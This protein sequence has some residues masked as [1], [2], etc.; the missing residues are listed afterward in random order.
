MLVER[1]GELVTREEIKK[2]LWPNDT[3]VEFDHSIHTA[4]NKLRQALGDSADRPKYVETVARRGYR[5]MVSVEYLESAP[6]DMHSSDES[7]GEEDS[8]AARLQ[9]AS[10][11]LIGRTVSHYRVLDV[12]GG[13]GMGVVYKAEDLKLGRAVALKFLPEEL[14]SDPRALERFSREA[15]AASSL[16]HPNICAIHEFGEHAGRPFMVMQLLEGQTL[17]DRLANTA[18]EGTLRL[19]ELLDIGIQVSD[20]LQAAHEKGII[21]RDI[22]PANIFITNKG[23]CKILDFGLV[24]LL[25][26]D[27]ED[28]VAEARDEPSKMASTA[29]TLTRTGMAMGT[30][31][32]M[33]PEQVRGEKL[34]AR[35]DLFSFGLVLYEMATGQRAF[36]GETA[37]VL[38]DAILNDMPTP[39]KGLNSTLPLK[40]EK[41]IGKAIEKQRE[42]RYQA[43]TD[44]RADLQTL[45]N[46]NRHGLLNR[47]WKYIL[48]AALVLVAIGSG[49]Y[50]RLHRTIHLSGNDTIVLADFANFTGDPIF[51]GALTC[52]LEIELRQSPFINLLSTEKVHNTLRQMNIPENTG[53][54]PL[55]VR[56]VCRRTNSR[57]EVEGS[58]ADRGNHYRIELKAVDCQTGNPLAVAG[59]EVAERNE[60]VRILGI[61]GLQLRDRLGEPKVSLQ[62]FDKPLEETVT[63]SPEALQEFT[64][65]KG[66]ASQGGFR[67]D[68]VIHYKRASELDPNFALA[69]GQLG[70]AYYN[71]GQTSL[72]T[73]NF[74]KLYE[75]RGRQTYQLQLE[76]EGLYYLS[77][78]GEL[79]K[80]I[81]S[82]M[83]LGQVYPSQRD[84]TH[85]QIG[86]MHNYLGQYEK[87]A[88]EEREAVRLDPGSI[89]PAGNLMLAYMA[90]N[91]SEE[92]RKVFEASR[93]RYLDEAQLRWIRYRLAFLQ[94]D[95]V[96][97]GEQVAWA[98]G[99]PTEDWILSEQANTAAYY[100]HLRS[101]GEFCRRAV[102]S[103]RNAGREE[104]A[105]QWRARQAL[106]EVETGNAVAARQ[107][108]AGALALSPGKVVVTA[109]ALA[110]ARAGN[111]TESL[112]LAGKLNQQFPLDTM[113]QN[114]SL[115]TIQAAIDLQNSNPRKAIETLNET[116]PYEL[117]NAS[118]DYAVFGNLLPVYLR[119]QAYL[120]DGQARQAAA[121]FQKVIDHP[122]IVLNFVTGALAHLQLARAQAMMGDKAAARNSYQDFLTLWK[123]ADPDIPIYQQAKAEY[124][125]LR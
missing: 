43:A 64:Q 44:M 108:A 100:G 12:I 99:K 27:Q 49:L 19:D 104:S 110:L 84:R 118:P 1:S 113:V 102:R 93:A 115:P 74:T 78:T 45:T 10:A 82:Y 119:G 122:G 66:I 65:A 116:A 96:T 24:K 16:D 112:T 57:V 88:A 58:I 114:Y 97:M 4:I 53:L 125:R 106:A 54:T 117:G 85:N 18:S 51:D 94:G 42:L 40:L 2:K 62:K 29:L 83:Q 77:V 55:V 87:A 101:A 6:E 38:K 35:T 61:A 30:A 28:E 34:D 120:Q 124:A 81:Q 37:A 70:F 13:G 123:D 63:S 17:R 47:Y 21:H 23:V 39:V 98:T 89:A 8:A 105:A 52:P 7:S 69:Y 79:E 107:M 25:E 103:A 32:Y 68:S 48:T 41:I 14:G 20:G 46:R 59:A 22:K 91:R 121:E 31:G 60:V 90:L 3:V 9:L 95:R 86:L 50:W 72:A 67:A 111:S 36:T 71:L 92:A 15:R 56:E 76:A 33:S 75:L 26:A 109:A 80:A 5:L 11:G 73:Q